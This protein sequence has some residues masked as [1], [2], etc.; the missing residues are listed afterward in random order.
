MDIERIRG[1][2]AQM[3][4][5]EK[6]ALVGGDAVTA[7]VGRLNVPSI[8]MGD[9]DPYSVNEPTALALGCTFSTSLCAAVS[10]M[11]VADAVRNKK[12]FAGTIGCGL[13]RDPMRPDAVD[14]FSEDVHVVKELLSA[15]ASAG[16][17]GYVFT[18]AL[19]QGRFT[20]RTVDSRAL[21]EL[22]LYPLEK[23]GQYAA[24]VQL[25]GGYL[26]GA[27]VAESREV[28]DLYAKFVPETA[29]F[30]TPH[31]YA[32]GTAGIAG[33]G[34]Y[35]LGATGADKKAIGRAV[36]D[37]KIYENKLNACVQR[38]VSTVVKTHEFYKNN[39]AK[40]TAS[41]NIVIDSTVLLKND[42]LLPTMPKD[43]A[44]FGNPYAFDD[45]FAFKMM[46]YRDA[47]KRHAAFNLFLI[48]DYDD[49]G[50]D[51]IAS[52][53]I[54]AVGKTAPTVVVLCGGAATP[55]PF[56]LFANAI[57]YCPYCP[58]VSAVIAMLTNT[59][60]RGHLPFTWAKDKREY[61]VNNR[62]FAERGDFRYESVYNGY[63][64][65]NNYAS[66]VMY[67][68]GHG[69]DYAKYDISKFSVSCDKLT[70]STEFIIKNSGEYA[71]SALVQVYITLLG[72]TAAYGQTRRLAAFRR[73]ALEATENSKVKI[74]VNL[75][76]FPVYDEANDALTPIGGKYKVEVGLSSTDI[77][78]SD[79]IKVP[80]GSRVNAGL[81]EALAPSYYVGDKK[82][83][84][85][86]SA[87]EIERLLKVPFIKK[88]DEYE[89]IV[90]PALAKVKHLIKKA[91]KTTEF[92]K[93]NL[94]KYKI[95]KTP[96][97]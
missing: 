33:C 56:A 3:K 32:C 18:D 66:H 68:F 86:P 48:N 7:A 14:F 40:Q 52:T 75:N 83:V 64:L 67:P 63:R 73:I 28:V 5:Q 27:R 72:G 76:D 30:I 71:G 57:L 21:R 49:D 70:I 79:E 34:A 82:K 61:P 45:G 85:N 58:T 53:A 95:E 80:V 16:A 74:D 35:Q 19:G 60:P 12:A 29:M 87:P 62:K 54:C 17:I 65:L 24:A 51:P 8:D 50:I 38:T 6:L 55:L 92:R 47:Q 78:A 90:P 11:R 1:A 31:G 42:G 36:V 88:P 93:L 97:N 44:I 91:E 81:S 46:P 4:L 39:T 96:I 13:I 69:L 94:V 23:A 2:I 10:K 89:D 37:G 20:N 15:Y 59:S 84:F 77:R 41:T 9:L 26:N 22:Y 25:D 43:I